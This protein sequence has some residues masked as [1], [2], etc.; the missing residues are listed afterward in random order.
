M[1]TMRV[2]LAG[3]LAALLS[4]CAGFDDYSQDSAHYRYG[5]GWILQLNRTLEIGAD[6]ASVRLQ[7]GRIVP[8]N[9]VQEQR[10]FCVFEIATVRSVPQA[11]APGRF[12]I[13]QVQRRVSTIAD[14]GAPAAPVGP[15]ALV[16]GGDSPSFLYYKTE[17]RL[18]AP[19]RPEL[20]GLTCMHDQLGTYGIMRHLTLDEIGATLG[21]WFSIIPP[22]GAR[23]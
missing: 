4:A 3:G 8:R 5:S 6:E 7:S 21:E 2:A 14:A 23:R 18:R 19:D 20:I 16:W 9:S 12:E 17:F 13:W 11:V 10:P 15:V 22:E 1:S